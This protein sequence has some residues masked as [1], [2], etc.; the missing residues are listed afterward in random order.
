MQK[1]RQA[2]SPAG[3]GLIGSYEWLGVKSLKL[4][5]CT[6]VVGKSKFVLDG[7]EV[8]VSIV[9]ARGAIEKFYD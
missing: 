2:C 4:F 3:E 8:A 9:E 7:D 5:A 6:G 1:R